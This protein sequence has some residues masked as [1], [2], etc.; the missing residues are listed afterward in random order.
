MLKFTEDGA[1]HTAS[2][3]YASDRGQ[4]SWVTIYQEE[5]I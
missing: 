3:Q 4:V 1:Q 2:S 5:A